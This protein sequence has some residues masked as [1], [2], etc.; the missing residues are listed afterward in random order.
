MDQLT[1]LGV[2]TRLTV[3]ILSPIVI[4]A[5]LLSLIRAY[6]TWSYYWR[7]RQF[8]ESPHAGKQLVQSPQIPYTLPFLGNS[9]SFLTPKPGAYWESLFSW[10]PRS[11]GVCSLVIGGKKT[12]ILFSQYAV[13]A[14][15]KA[16]SPSRDVFELELFQK[17]FEL[18]PEQTHNAMA[19][20]HHEHEMNSQYLTKHERVNELTSGFT[21]V[22]DEVTAKDA[23]NLAGM[24]EFGL[25][26]WLQQRMFTASVTALMGDK[27]P[28][29]F[30]DFGDA[31]KQFDSDFLS[32]F[33][34]L[35]KVM[36]GDALKNRTRIFDKLEEWAKEMHVLSGGAPIDPEGP[37][38]EPLMG[39]R[40]NRARQLDYKKRKLNTRSAACFDL[41]IVFGLASN[42]IP[43]TGWMLMHLLNPLGDA[44][45][46][47]RVLADV[48]HSENADGSIDIPTLVASPLLQSM[49][50]ETLRMYTDVLVTRNI[51]EDINLPLDADGK[52][53]VTFHKGDNIFAPCWLGH[54]DPVA[55][56]KGEAPYDQ[57]YAERFLT[58]D[59]ATGK[60]A[61]TMNGTTGKYFPF[62]GGRTICPGRVF[63]KQEG[64]GALAMVLLR[65]D[66]DV[67]GFVDGEG[68]PSQTFPGFA[69]AFAGSG[70]LAPGGDIKIRMR[71]RV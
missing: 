35:P 38:W 9:L 61:F 53:Q 51:T 32:F 11:T 27:L 47:P 26:D 48:R 21:R 15:F 67:V 14:L 45:L 25:Y 52:R 70:A 68:K 1:S 43:A 55:W 60:E 30:P 2:G 28:E 29:M 20:K 57:F 22:L 41:G 63:A 17:V 71:K 4:G 50:T 33:F 46:L 42:V 40:L 10:H 49:W 62:G 13:Q 7:L 34:G 36:M 59:P 66:F 65:F 39:S 3:Y 69:K 54:H 31:F 12:H 19:G 24:G 18:T 58:T 23:E 44:T 16:K 5:L 8:V 6:T 56:A 64:L 37:A